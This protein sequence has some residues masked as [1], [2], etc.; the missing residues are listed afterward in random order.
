MTPRHRLLR[1]LRG[2]RVDRVPLV[3]PGFQCSS[4][5]GLTEIGDPRRRQVAERV[6]DRLHFDVGVPAHA[7]RM[8]VT[9][10]QR[11][12][13]EAEELAGGHRRIRGVIDTPKG[14]LAFVREWSPE[15]NTSWAIK[16]PVSTYEEIEK[17]ASV[18]WERPEGLAPPDLGELPADF[19]RRGI[20]ATRISSPFVCVA[21]MMPREWFLEL[22][23]TD[24]EL[25][26]ELTDICR[27]RML[28]ILG[29][30]LSRPGIEY[31]WIG[32]SE[33]VTPPM[34]SPRIYDALVQEQE[35][36]L[37]ACA[38]EKAGAVA[39]IHCHGRVRHALRRTI[40]R[41]G[42]YTEPVEPP[43]DG[44]I[45]MAEAK[46]LAAGRITLGGN[47][48]CRVLAYGTREDVERA[49]RA[50]FEGGKER[51]VLRPTEGP[52]PRLD[53]R[54]FENWMIMIDLWEELSPIP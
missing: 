3:L 2:G 36:D 4:R 1:T 8:L 12:R 22:C 40:E 49:V 15:A 13:T 32:G 31:V 52:S 26:R 37:I 16:H 39:H 42:D 41:G 6:F 11:I 38:H 51:F 50:A 25:V 7:N 9:P 53:P 28:D 48:E 33:W 29:V 14:E 35:R 5:E 30:L 43:P 23:L 18:P 24:L 47:I 10:P 44:D 45:T 54:E 21:G 20:V 27:Q 17:I 46:A 34:A 19:P